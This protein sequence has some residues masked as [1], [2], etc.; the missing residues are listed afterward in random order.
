[1][2][3]KRNG[4]WWLAVVALCCVAPAAFADHAQLKPK[5]YVPEGGT[6]ATYLLGVGLTCFGGMFLRFRA[7][8]PTRS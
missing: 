3:S 2:N 6:T 5:K 4:K 1:M 7:A 8:K